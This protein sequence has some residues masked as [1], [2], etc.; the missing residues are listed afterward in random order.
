MHT[1]SQSGS[2]SSPSSS[3]VSTSASAAQ[4]KTVVGTLGSRSDES[5]YGGGPLSSGYLS[6]NIVYT[7]ALRSMKTS[8]ILAFST[9]CSFSG[10]A[11]FMHFKILRL[12]MRYGSRLTLCVAMSLKLFSWYAHFSS[13]SFHVATCCSIRSG[14]CFNASVEV[15]CRL[16]PNARAG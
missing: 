5:S 13:P 3:P 4:S 16:N 7:C 9:R 10:K 11:S 2:L 15:T 14:H 12:S 8:S 1:S 6:S